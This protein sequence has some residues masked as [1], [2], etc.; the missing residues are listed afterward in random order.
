M[1]SRLTGGRED[2]LRTAWDGDRSHR[3]AQ[4]ASGAS[5]AA[6]STRRGRPEGG[7]RLCLRTGGT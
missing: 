5:D 6:R 2:F 7:R 1:R 3:L 4:G